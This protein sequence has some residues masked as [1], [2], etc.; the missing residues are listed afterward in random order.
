V[1]KA[2]VLLLGLMV[3]A[4]IAVAQDKPA[5]TMD[6]RM[7]NPGRWDI[8]GIL[9][10]DDPL[11]D[12]G[13]DYSA[14]PM[15]TCD[16]PFV[17]HS[18]DPAAFEAYCIQ[19]IDDT[20]IEVEF[21]ADLTEVSDTTLYLFCAGFDPELP[22]E[23]GVFWDDDDGVGLMSAF[24]LADNIVLEPGVDYILVASVYYHTTGLGAYTMH[25]SDNLMACPVSA[26][27]SNWSTLK[28]LYR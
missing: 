24:T 26:E 5:D 21:D 12:R 9:D 7:Q 25:L 6:Y 14:P 22:L 4:G 1:K 27:N 10:A 2:I 15:P 28:S 20:P 11:W 19:A 8:T 13:V 3:F 23:E 18:S 16:F 17:D